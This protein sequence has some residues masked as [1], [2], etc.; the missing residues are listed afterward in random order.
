MT[1]IVF[2]DIDDSLVFSRRKSQ[3]GSQA[4]AYRR[5]GEPGSYMSPGQRR[6]FE[7]LARDAELIPA[8]ARNVDALRR[9]HLP[10]HSY[11]VCSHGGIIIAPDGE[12]EPDWLARTTAAARRHAA[13]LQALH[14]AALRW[15]ARLG[16]DV[17]A[18]VVQD[19]GLPLYLSIKHNQR[20]SRE[21]ARLGQRLRHDVPDGWS[22]Y[23]NDNSLSALPPFL[24]K[25]HAVA[26][27]LDQRLDSGRPVLGLGDS[28]SDLP[29]LEKCDYAVVPRPSQLFRKLASDDDAAE[30]G[31]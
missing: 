9:V 14:D 30:I 1:P 29:F 21:L 27:L 18:T 12:L 23:W 24:G 26:Y 17:R 5:D 10:F 13:D 3:A 31:G 6:F 8:T 22:F 15:G 4:V 7:W 25:Q 19:A 28:L 16:I 2:V 11:A 20:L